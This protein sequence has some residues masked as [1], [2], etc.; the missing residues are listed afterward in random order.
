M[1]VKYIFV[2]GGMRCGPVRIFRKIVIAVLYL[3]GT[4]LYSYFFTLLIMSIPLLLALKT[5]LMQ[6]HAVIFYV[7]CCDARE[8]EC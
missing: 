6:V 1:Y 7:L 4:L 5:I 2:Y 8:H 3:L